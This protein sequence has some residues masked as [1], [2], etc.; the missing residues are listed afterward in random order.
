M[1]EK[2][3]IPGL[4]EGVGKLMVDTQSDLRLGMV[5]RGGGWQGAKAEVRGV[6]PGQET[7]CKGP[8]VPGS[9]EDLKGGMGLEGLG[10]VRWM[11]GG[12]S[13]DDGEPGMEALYWLPR[14]PCSGLAPI[15]FPPAE[16]PPPA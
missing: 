4:H 12:L 14:P 2:A 16:A 13:G 15:P 10:P 5:Q 7:L 1:M 11:E 3:K 8:G 6:S 9:V